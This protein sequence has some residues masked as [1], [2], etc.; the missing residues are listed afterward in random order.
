LRELWLWRDHEAQSIDRPPFHILQNHLLLQS[1]KDFEAGKTP[2]FRHF[3]PRRR[4]GFLAAAERALQLPESEL[5]K[6]VRGPHGI[7]PTQ[8]MEK[9]AENLRK[10]RDVVAEQLGID[11]SFIAP[12]ATVESIAADQSRSE[13]LL[14]PWQRDLL[15]V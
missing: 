15:E 12:R 3:T 13:T 2:E 10:R 1:A 4:R 11:P 6:R 14:V 7:R 9:A 5:P 8:E